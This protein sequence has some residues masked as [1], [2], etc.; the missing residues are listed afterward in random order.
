MFATEDDLDGKEKHS[1]LGD[2]MLTLFLLEGSKG[3]NK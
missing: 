3:D 2:F 1:S